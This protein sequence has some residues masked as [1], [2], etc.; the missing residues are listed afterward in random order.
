MFEFD[1]KVIQKNRFLCL[2]DNKADCVLN[3]TFQNF[4]YSS[5]DERSVR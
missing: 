3:R 1:D 5:G 4:Y 2:I